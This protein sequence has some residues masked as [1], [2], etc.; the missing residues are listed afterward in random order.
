MF[1][2]NRDAGV[3][4]GRS[5]RMR[6]AEATTL[7]EAKPGKSLPW[8]RNTISIAPSGQC[9]GPAIQ[10]DEPDQSQRTAE[11]IRA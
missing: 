9:D 10:H 3:I 7:E 6:R 4:E 5:L 11:Q 1:V 8:P 2:M